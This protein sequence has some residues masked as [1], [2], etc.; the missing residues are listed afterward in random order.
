MTIVAVHDLIKSILALS[1]KCSSSKLQL[2]NFTC[3]FSLVC[4][5]L[6]RPSGVCFRV[7]FTK[8]CA[9]CRWIIAILLTSCLY[10][11]LYSMFWF[12][13]CSKSFVFNYSGIADRTDSGNSYRSC[14]YS[15]HHN[16]CSLHQEE[17]GCQ[18]TR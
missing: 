16:S 2:Q 5:F 3:M 17:T 6:C 14:G 10:S 1:D 12:H 13:V 8:I 15:C 4:L 11:D 18:E 9:L 7:F